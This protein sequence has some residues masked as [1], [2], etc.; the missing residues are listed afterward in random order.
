MTLRRGR[1]IE[2]RGGYQN[3]KMIVFT[4]TVDDWDDA[5][6]GLAVVKCFGIEQRLLE[7]ID[8]NLPD[9]I[10]YMT[11]AFRDLDAVQHPVYNIPAFDAW[12]MELAMREL[13]SRGG[14]DASNLRTPVQ[15]RS[16]ENTLTTVID[17]T[18]QTVDRFR[19]RSMSAKSSPNRFTSR[20]ANL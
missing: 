8:R 14:I 12:P 13:A 9:R 18:N 2:I 10:S 4:G 11:H 15:V 3:N 19:A 6:S 16:N 20:P 17:S 1:A 7:R 5:S